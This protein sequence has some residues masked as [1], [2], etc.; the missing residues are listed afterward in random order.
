[1]RQLVVTVAYHASEAGARQFHITE[2]GEVAGGRGG[3]RCYSRLLAPNLGVVGALKECPC[4]GPGLSLIAYQRV[5]CEL[6]N[7]ATLSMPM[8]YLQLCTA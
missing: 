7:W 2:P 5:S 1:M 8:G 4:K 3:C 6:P